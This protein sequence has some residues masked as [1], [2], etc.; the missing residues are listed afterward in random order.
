MRSGKNRNAGLSLV[1]LLIALA[2]GMIVVSAVVLL[3][4]QGTN[5]YR[6]QT[7]TA[8]LQEDANIAMNQISDAVMEADRLLVSVSD[9]D[10]RSTASF[11]VNENTTYIYDMGEKTLYVRSGL[12]GSMSA[13]SVLCQNVSA[14]HVQLVTDSVKREEISPGVTKI[15]GISNPVQVKITIEVSADRINRK[16]SRVTGV[17]NTVKFEN[18]ALGGALLDTLPVSEVLDKYGFLTD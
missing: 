14:F 12:P 10:T 16:I 9:S 2:I 6:R 1:E 3:I 4:V 15:T 17:R 13:D 18:I 5:S 7:L 11:Q 8:Q